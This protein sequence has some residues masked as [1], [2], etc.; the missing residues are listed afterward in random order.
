MKADSSDDC[1]GF[2]LLHFKITVIIVVF[3]HKC[4]THQEGRNENERP[5]LELGDTLRAAEVENV[6]LWQRGLVLRQG[7][8]LAEVTRRFCVC[9]DRQ[10]W[11]L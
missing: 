4:R 2:K 11:L 5:H 1:A 6:A 3:I 9:A 7:V 10:C 8:P